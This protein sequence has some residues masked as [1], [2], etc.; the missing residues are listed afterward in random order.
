ME[1]PDILPEIKYVDVSNEDYRKIQAL[2]SMQ[3]ERLT[4]EDLSVFDN[5]QEIFDSLNSRET[6]RGRSE[7]ISPPRN[8]SQK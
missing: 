3:P 8:R 4:L 2:F 5:A 6:M 1:I 7:E